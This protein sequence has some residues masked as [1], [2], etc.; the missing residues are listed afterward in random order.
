V[1]AH[2]REKKARQRSALAAKKKS[3]LS[4]FAPV[5]PIERA[6][7]SAPQKIETFSALY[8]F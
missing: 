8:F 3:E 2:A 1:L 4:L 6:L 7:L 5:W